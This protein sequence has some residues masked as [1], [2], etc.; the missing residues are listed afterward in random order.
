MDGIHSN[1]IDLTNGKT[2]CQSHVSYTITETS[3]VVI[4]R[5]LHSCVY[6]RFLIIKT[7]HHSLRCPVAQTT[8]S[9]AAHIQRR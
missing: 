2:R 7:M 6:W 5:K 1:T 8:P 9:T 3:N 4:L